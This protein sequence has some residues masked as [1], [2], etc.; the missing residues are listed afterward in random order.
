M[1]ITAVHKV[2]GTRITVRPDQNLRDDYPEWDQLQ[3]PITGLP[4][5]P[6]R[7]HAR[8]GVSGPIKVRSYFRIKAPSDQSTWP[9]DVIF[10]P[11]YGIERKGI[12]FFKGESWEHL[13]GK[14]FVASQLQS[15]LGPTAT[16]EF[17][18]VVKL[19]DGRRRIADIA[20][21]FPSGYTE[22]HEIQLSPISVEE[23][24]ARTDDYAS[25]GI[26]AQ[27][28]IGKSNTDRHD[29]RDCLRQLQGG[30]YVLDFEECLPGAISTPEPDPADAFDF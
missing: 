30:F 5:F 3:C 7:S 2:T 10:D 23:L 1:T 18:H 13:E 6:V 9:V 26:P 4:V 28:W 22:V 12:R 17:E 24:N 16:V 20:V 8:S 27:W 19:P 11:E 15:M 21:I 25:V 14:A 29:I